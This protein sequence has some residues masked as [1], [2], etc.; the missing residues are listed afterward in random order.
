[1]KFEELCLGLSNL[2]RAF[3]G[4]PQLE[5]DETLAE[6]SKAWANYLNSIQVIKNLFFPFSSSLSHLYPCSLM[7]EA[8]HWSSEGY[9]LYT[10]VTFA[11]PSQSM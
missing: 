4:A 3:Y 2:F 5:W 11:L 9:M 7:V 8:S 1:M 10:Y 6:S